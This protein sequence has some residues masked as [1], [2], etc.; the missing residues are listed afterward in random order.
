M[1]TFRLPIQDTLAG[2][3]LLTAQPVVVDESTPQK[4][5]T[6][7][8]VHS[9]IY[10]PLL[11]K[12]KVI[13]VLGV[14][15]RNNRLPFQK[16]DIDLLSTLAEYAVIALLN[17]NLFNDTRAERNKLDTILRRVQDGVVVVDRARNILIINQAAETSLGVVASEAVGKLAGGSSAS[18]RG[19]G[20][21]RGSYRQ[22]IQP[23]RVHNQR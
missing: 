16:H 12:T 1:R 17:A 22:P 18:T 8:L 5:K 10:V 21:A 2:N 6:S 13:G 15:N 3:V 20:L 9:L 19:C 11:L 23:H 7:Y 14:D 4:I